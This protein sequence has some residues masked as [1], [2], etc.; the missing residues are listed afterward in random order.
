MKTLREYIDLIDS[1]DQSMAEGLEDTNVQ[2]AIFDT[3]KR[4]FHKNEIGDYGALEAIRQ[5]IKHHFL[6]P[7]ATVESAIDGI[8]N[9][10]DKRRNKG[11]YYLELTRFKEALRQGVAHQLK[12]QGVAEAEEHGLDNKYRR[13]AKA[14]IQVYE[15][16]PKV[17]AK[18]DN[19][20]E[21]FRAMVY[22][23]GVVKNPR[24]LDGT[25]HY[26]RIV[27]E[28][29]SIFHYGYKQGV[30]EEATPEAIKQIE[31]LSKQ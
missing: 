13:I 18:V 20:P 3:V 7:G 17:K 30:A 19:S 9:I 4:L 22:E 29:E 27:D 16:D 1:A 11:D 21:F 26:L 2:D 14:M 10:L 8:L 12:K 6:K 15:T 25:T 31:E 5:G 28:L 24:Q 23:T